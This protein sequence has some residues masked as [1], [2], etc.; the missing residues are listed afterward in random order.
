MKQS[1][2][3]WLNR[4]LA[5]VI[6]RK[7][8]NRASMLIVMIGPIAFL[9]QAYEVHQGNTEGV[10]LP[11]FLIFAL[12]QLTFSLVGVQKHDHRVFW[13]NIASFAL[14]LYIIVLLSI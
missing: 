10:S 3:D 13:S 6:E 7:W 14:T 12:I 4:H 9:P 1:M 8:F 5:W 2:F 11:M